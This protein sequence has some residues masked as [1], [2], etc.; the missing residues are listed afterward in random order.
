MILGIDTSTDQASVALAS[1]GVIVAELSWS[2]K[3]NHSRHLS[4]VI[5]YMTNLVE[6]QI[7]AIDR[8]AV[9]SGPG[10][11]SGVRVAISVAK[12]IGLATGAPVVGISTLDVIGFQACHLSDS[13]IV[14]LEAGRGEVFVGQF[15]GD[16][17][18]F[19][20]LA[21]P[22]IMSLAEAARHAEEF[23][24]VAGHAAVAV[25]RVP[26]DHPRP[27]EEPDAMRV[28][29]AGFLAE[30]G[31]RY[32]DAGGADQIDILEPMYLRKSAAEEKR[33]NQGR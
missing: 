23:Q 29:R 19:H 11:F 9:A 3:N 13:A 2:V 7:S 10:G 6:V 28:R 17:R 12:G 20:R 8:L 1:D 26:G 31:K 24:M 14:F 21:D 25:I 18:T 16:P 4:R 15:A 27:L 33:A 5:E 32:F 30:L 22:Q